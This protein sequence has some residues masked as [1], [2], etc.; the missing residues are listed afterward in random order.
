MQ[1]LEVS[2]AVRTLQASL[3]FKGLNKIMAVQ[4]LYF[5]F[6][7]FFFPYSPI[8]V[9]YCSFSVRCKVMDSCDCEEH[10]LIGCD[11]M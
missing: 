4:K 7:S 10:Y 6:A 5:T 9:Q 1:R 8:C 2:G 3:G 11:D